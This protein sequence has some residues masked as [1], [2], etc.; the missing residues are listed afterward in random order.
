ML[1]KT[2]T[3]FTDAS[4][5]AKQHAQEIGAM[6]KL[7]REGNIWVVVSSHEKTT[8]TSS[9]V[10]RHML[11]SRRTTYIPKTTWLERHLDKQHKIEKQ[12]KKPTEL[13]RKA[14]K[15]QRQG[16]ENRY[17]YLKERENYYRSLSEVQLEKLWNEREKMELESDETTLLREIV[18][19]VKKIKPAY[20]NSV[21]V[22][23]QCGMVGDNCTCGRSWF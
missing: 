2:F 11:P 13:L 1:R 15:V 5:Y 22:C 23:R 20:G 4:N 16:Q 19:E 10:D 14:Y 3:T 8:T 18:R 6:V 17:T 7:E 21:K 12:E 9:I